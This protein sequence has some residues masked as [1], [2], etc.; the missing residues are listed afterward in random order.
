MYLLFLWYELLT[1]EIFFSFSGNVL[2]VRAVRNMAIGDEVFNC[3]GAHHIRMTKSMRKT[4]LTEQYN[5]DCT[6]IPCTLPFDIAVSIFGHEEF[7]ETAK[8]F[9]KNS[10][11]HS[12]LF[13]W[14]ELFSFHFLL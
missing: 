5:F 13:H 12:G 2:V 9:G 7:L 10:L 14:Y 11:L 1:D 6:C 8:H 4:I 3:Y